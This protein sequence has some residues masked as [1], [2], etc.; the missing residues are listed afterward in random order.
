MTQLKGQPLTLLQYFTP[1]PLVLDLSL[2]SQNVRLETN[3][4]EILQKTA[5]ALGQ[6]GSSSV[7]RSQFLWRLVGDDDDP[8][9]AGAG[10]GKA[11]SDAAWPPPTGFGHEGLSFVNFGQRGFL[12]IDASAGRALGFLPQAWVRDEEGFTAVFLNLL[13]GLTAAA[14]GS[15]RDPEY[16]TESNCECE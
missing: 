6:A 13:M 2:G 15:T 8:G 12:A 10:E 3:S 11:G 9:G 7:E 4:P 16:L 5:L 1:T 14:L